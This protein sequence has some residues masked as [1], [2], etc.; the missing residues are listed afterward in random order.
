MTNQ[1]LI[2]LHIQKRSLLTAG[3]IILQMAQKLFDHNTH[4]SNAGSNR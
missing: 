2:Y 3:N 4:Y 1:V